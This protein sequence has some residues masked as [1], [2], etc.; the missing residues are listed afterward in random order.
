MDAIKLASTYFFGTEDYILSNSMIATV[1]FKRRIDAEKL[2]FSYR[3]LIMDNPLL[4]A[5]RVEQFEKDTFVWGRFS[6]E[7]LEHFLEAEKVKLSQY[8]TEEEVLAQ[9]RPTNAR[10]PFRIYPINEY[11]MIFAMNH[12]VANGLS[13]VLDQEM[14]GILLRRTR[15]RAG[16]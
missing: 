6:Q 8:F 12:A 13:L 3:S 1:T 2:F 14:A 11:T 10:L 15:F 9:Y 16:K 4:Q 7:E 5:K